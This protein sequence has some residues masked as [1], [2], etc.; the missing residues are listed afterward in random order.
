MITISLTQI[1]DKSLYQDEWEKLLKSKGGTAADMAAQFPLSDVLDSNNLDD[2]LWC[3]RCLPEHDRLWRKYAVWCARQVQHLMTD[4][5]SINALDVAWRHSNGEATDAELAAAF[6]LAE[7]VVAPGAAAAAWAAKTALAA[8]AA[9][10]ADAAEIAWASD[11]ALAALAALA[12]DAATHVA[13]DAAWAAARTAARAAVW[14]AADGAR[15][16]KGTAARAAQKEKL[17]EILTAGQWVTA[18]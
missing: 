5:R 8:L 16:Y 11:A 9:D 14:A 4:Q 6:G 2:T 7:A 18:S 17:M 10:A 3:L 15:D 1:R 12:A 13:C